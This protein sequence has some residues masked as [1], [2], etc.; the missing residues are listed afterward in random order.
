MHGW[1]QR[2]ARDVDA[3]VPIGML[4]DFDA[5]PRIP[6]LDIVAERD[7]PETL[8]SA[9]LRAPRLPRD[10]CSAPVTLASTDHFLDHAVPRAVERIVPFLDKVFAND[11]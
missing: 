2:A 9:K 7:F 4:V 6:V 11:C 8:A 10:R 3:W 1:L 5:P